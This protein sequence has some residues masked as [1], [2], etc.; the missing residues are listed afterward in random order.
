MCTIHSFSAIVAK[1]RRRIRKVEDDRLLMDYNHLSKMR[2]VGLA[3]D[4]IKSFFPSG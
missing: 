1:H 4:T 3:S 2:Y